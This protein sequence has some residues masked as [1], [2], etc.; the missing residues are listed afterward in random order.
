MHRAKSIEKLIVATSIDASDD[1]LADLC[2]ARGIEVSRGPLDDVLERFV[3]AATPYNPVW[4]VRMTGDCPLADPQVIDAAV[5][6]AKSGIFDYVTNALQ[7][8][9]PDGL[10]VEVVRAS[11]LEVARREAKLASE[12]EHVTPFIYKRPQRFRLEHL[13]SSAKL[14]HLRWTVDELRDFELVTKIYEELYPINPEFATTD[15]LELI[16]R[17]PELE[18]YNTSIPRNEGYVNSLQK[19]KR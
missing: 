14:E 15:I 10:D 7:P 8:S 17:R 5:E 16:R 2:I 6:L 12:R 11:V 13:Y 3:L 4:I 18:Q 9:F 19:D 1:E